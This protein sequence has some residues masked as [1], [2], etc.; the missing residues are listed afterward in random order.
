PIPIVIPCHRIVAKSG[1]G[2]FS[3]QTAGEK[4][5]IK[6][7]LLGHEGMSSVKR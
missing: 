1:L 6:R 4:M 2:G 7:W 5:Q 3:G